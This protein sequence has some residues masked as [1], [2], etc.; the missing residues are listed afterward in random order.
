MTLVHIVEAGLTNPFVIAVAT[1]IS[2]LS[3]TSPTVEH[4]VRS[5]NQVRK[6][7]DD[8]RQTLVVRDR[9]AESIFAAPRRGGG[10]QGQQKSRLGQL[11]LATFSCAPKGGPAIWVPE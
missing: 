4:G 2:E 6:R 9:A 10:R 5:G 11:P 3:L 8:E 1:G 7:R